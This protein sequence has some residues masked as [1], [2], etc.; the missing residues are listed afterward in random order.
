VSSSNE[1]NKDLVEHLLA[2][3]AV[4]FSILPTVIAFL[5]ADGL[6][7]SEQG[8]VSSFISDIGDELA[9]IA[10]YINAKSRT[11]DAAAEECKKEYEKIR[12]ILDNLLQENRC[13]QNRIAYL[14][15]RIK[16]L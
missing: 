15:N 7:P 11:E 9:G 16:T 3:D 4:T 5:L 2:L 1:F 10:L 8:V 6:T 14:E 13:M 12:L